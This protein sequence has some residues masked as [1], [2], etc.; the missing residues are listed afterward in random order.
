MDVIKNLTNLY[1]QTPIGN[2]NFYILRTLL[3]N[4]PELEDMTVYDIAELANTSRTTVWRLLKQMGYGS[5]TAFKVALSTAV[6]RYSLYN[7]GEFGYALSDTAASVDRVRE[8]LQNVLVNVEHTNL[9]RLEAAAALL[10][11]A[12]QVSFYCY[13]PISYLSELQQNLSFCGKTTAMRLTLPEMLVDAAWMD[14]SGVALVQPFEFPQGLDMEPLFEVLNKN[15]C[16][17]L[18]L[19]PGDRS[20]YGKYAA[21]SLTDVFDFLPAGGG[22]GTAAFLCVLNETYRGRYMAD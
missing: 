4:L 6:S 3:R 17:I 7:K 19:G 11:D 20:K 18:L 22:F 13:E 15:G 12:E 16:R 5:F 21:F 1:N 9:A 14:A 10:Y 8:R 2:S